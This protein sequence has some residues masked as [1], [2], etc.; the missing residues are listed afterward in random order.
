MSK[1]IYSHYASHLKK[2]ECQTVHFGGTPKLVMSLYNSF[3][4][5]YLLIM[6]LISG[7][8]IESATL[9]E[10]VCHQTHDPPFCLNILGSDPR[11]KNAGLPELAGITIDLGSYSAT[12]TKVKIH[13]LLLSGKFPQLK[14]RLTVCDENYAHAI[15]ELREAAVRLKHGEYIDLNVDGGLAGQDGHDCE[16]AFKEPPAYR[17]PLTH[18]NYRLERF[19]EIITI[20]A[21]LLD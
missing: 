8:L 15:S 19:G 17:S 4:C 5:M 10:E 11:T 6:F 12:G 2:S 18:E 14:T 20:I 1:I 13:S 9:L 7:K 16:E 21:N 3:S